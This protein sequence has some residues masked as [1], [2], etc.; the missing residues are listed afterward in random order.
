MSD[1]FLCS[2]TFRTDWVLSH[3]YDDVRPDERITDALCLAMKISE[4]HSKPGELSFKAA[5]EGVEEPHDLRR[6]ICD[7]ITALFGAADSDIIDEITVEELTAEQPLQEEPAPS[8]E[9]A[10]AEA[11]PDKEEASVQEQPEGEGVSLLQRLMKKSA[12]STETQC[13]D[14]DKRTAMEKINA[15]VGADEFKALAAECARVMPYLCESN[16]LDSFKKRMYVISVNNGYGLSEYIS[17]FSQ[18]LEELGAAGKNK[19][20]KP[21]EIQM[22]SDKKDEAYSE[23]IGK[24]RNLSDTVVCIDISEFMSKTGDTEFKQ[25]LK[26][27]ED[28]AGNNVIF[29]RIPFVERNVLQKIRSDL[30]DYVFIKELSIVPFTLSQLRSYA[31]QTLVEKGFHADEDTM[32]L[33]EQRMIEEKNDGRFYGLNTVNKVLSELLYLK[34]LYNAENDLHDKEIAGSQVQSILLTAGSERQSGMNAF[35]RLVGMDDI[36]HKVEEIVSQIKL[37]CKNDKLDRPCIH[38]RFTGNPGT[39]KTTVARILGEV[40]K[41]EGILRNGSFFEYA[42]RD[43]CGRYVGET[44]PKTAAMCRDAYGSVMFIDEAYSLYRGEGI[45]RADYGQEAIDTLVAEMENHRTDLVV[46]MAGYEREMEK[47]MSSNPGL[48]SRMPF[49]IEFPNYTR[50][51]LAAIFLRMAQASFVYDEQFE[52]AVNDYFMNL[53]DEIIQA[54][55]FSNAR[56]V[57]NLYERTWGKLALRAQLSGV[58]TDRLIVEDF[59]LAV[60]EKEFKN[61]M[62]QKTARIGFA[63]GDE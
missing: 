15:L 47:L 37:A 13:Q 16:T 48:R 17:L 52:Q 32:Q 62:E 45:S 39:G 57:R 9:S 21:V 28:Y 41:E 10:P 56:Y 5:L 34:Q 22:Q 59:A 60:S 25:F 8:Q 27:I 6:D 29:F 18:L 36:R 63:A 61:I 44:A 14:T 43:F 11:Q 51:Q 23:A 1:Q 20:M 46:I 42:G 49:K 7:Q 38:M 30:N 55:D 2:I 50:E 35:D 53:S 4:I 12:D 54:E 3:M 19:K 26:K 58:Q 31:E 40:L 33:V 24:L